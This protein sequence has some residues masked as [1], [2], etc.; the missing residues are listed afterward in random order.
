MNL[1][2]YTIKQEKRRIE[3]MIQKYQEELSSLPKGVISIKKVGEKTYYY[4]K[5]RDGKKVISQYVRKGEIEGVCALVEKRQHIEAMMKSLQEEKA[6]ADKA[7]EGA[8]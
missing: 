5:Y 4:L 8:I 7:L 2:L 6:I 1:I 3:Y